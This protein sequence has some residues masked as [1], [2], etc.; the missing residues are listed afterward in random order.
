MS[1]VTPRR[2]PIMA[3]KT[4]VDRP[5]HHLRP[6]LTVLAFLVPMAWLTVYYYDQPQ[7]APFVPTNIMVLDLLKVDI[8]LVVVMALLHTRHLVTAISEWRHK[9]HGPGHHRTR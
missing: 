6:V 4:D 9:L 5:V 1:V 8:F 3:P 2:T 7:H